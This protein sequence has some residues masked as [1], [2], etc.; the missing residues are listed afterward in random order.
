MGRRIQRGEREFQVGTSLKPET[1]KVNMEVFTIEGFTGHS[2]RNELLKQ[3]SKDLL[4]QTETI[5]FKVDVFMYEKY[6]DIIELSENSIL[7]NNDSL[8]EEI[9]LEYA[10]RGINQLVIE[11]VGPLWIAATGAKGAVADVEDTL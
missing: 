5:L 11:E 9:T 8:P 7:R 4:E 6:K 3:S 1:L 2:G 10:R